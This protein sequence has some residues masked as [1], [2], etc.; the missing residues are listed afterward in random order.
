MPIEKWLPAPAYEGF[1]EVS[2]LGRVRSVDRVVTRHYRDGRTTTVTRC[3]QTMKFDYRDGYATVRLQANRRTFK[4]YVHRL[5]CEA[6]NGPCPE[7]KSIAAH[8]DGDFTHNWSENLRWATEAENQRD[9]EGHG[10]HNRGERSHLAKL[11]WDDASEIRRSGEP[12]SLLA[13]RF[14]VTPAN[15]RMIR[16][17]A[18]WVPLA[19]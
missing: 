4:A 6:F 14:G 3:G 16:R 15:I 11:T 10:T 19:A 12:T 18:T 9:R 17:G 7:G 2:S 8:N 5:V 13:S 1:Y